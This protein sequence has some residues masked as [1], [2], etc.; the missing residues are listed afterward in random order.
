MDY[1]LNRWNRFV[2]FI[3]DGRICLTNKA[4]ERAPR[5]F[6]PCATLR[7]SPVPTVAPTA[8]R[9]TVTLIMTAYAA[10]GRTPLS[11]WYGRSR[12]RQKSCEEFDGP[13]PRLDWTAATA[14]TS[15]G[16]A[17]PEDGSACTAALPSLKRLTP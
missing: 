3:D 8:P 15:S 2:R 7:C 17:T 14:S 11:R 12:A 5:G 16:I 13:F 1:R 10:R 6:C 4:A 9:F